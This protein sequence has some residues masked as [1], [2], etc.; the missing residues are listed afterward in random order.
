MLFQLWEE[1]Y[2]E[3]NTPCLEVVDTVEDTVQVILFK[4]LFNSSTP[5]FGKRAMKRFARL[6]KKG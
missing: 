2:K 3:I 6:H 5:R 1:S 4:T